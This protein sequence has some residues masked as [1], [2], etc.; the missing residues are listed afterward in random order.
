MKLRAPLVIITGEQAPVCPREPNSHKFRIGVSTH[1]LKD[2][3]A[4]ESRTAYCKVAADLITYSL[5]VITGDIKGSAAELTSEMVDTGQRFLAS[6]KKLSTGDQDDALQCFLFSLFNQKRH[7]ETSKYAFLV[8][9]FLVL[10]SFTKTGS[11]RTCN[12]FTQYFSK[13]I[14]FARAAI[15]NRITSEATRDAKGFY[16]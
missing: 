7:G 12:T 16:E 2:L 11:L 4:K 10:Y 5:G 13:V 9:N 15:L 14:F 3:Q 1:K 6:L 8:Y